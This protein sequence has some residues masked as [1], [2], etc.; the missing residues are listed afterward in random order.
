MFLVCSHSWEVFLWINHSYRLSYSAIVTLAATP[1]SFIIFIFQKDLA[2]IDLHYGTSLAFQ[3][4]LYWYNCWGKDE[5]NLWSNISPQ[6][7]LEVSPPNCDPHR[8]SSFTPGVWAALNC[9]IGLLCLVIRRGWKLFFKL[10]NN[11]SLAEQVLDLS[12]LKSEL[13]FCLSLFKWP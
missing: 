13:M 4:N 10:Y 2:K 3:R 5:R 7:L 8:H 6:A 12:R 9:G 1:T 11:G